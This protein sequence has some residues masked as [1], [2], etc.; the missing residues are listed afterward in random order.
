MKRIKINKHKIIF[1]LILFVVIMF[2]LIPKVNLIFERFNSPFKYDEALDKNIN[3]LKIISSDCIIALYDGELKEYF[4]HDKTFG[5]TLFSLKDYSINEDNIA[6]DCKGVLFK[7]QD[8][9]HNYLK[10]KNFNNGEITNIVSTDK[11]NSI[12]MYIEDDKVIYYLKDNNTMKINFFNVKTNKN[13]LILELE[14][15]MNEENY[16]YLSQPSIDDD[17]IV[18]SN[19]KKNEFD[20]K[21]SELY[22]FNIGNYEIKNLNTKKD[23][24]YKPIVYNNKLLGLKENIVSEIVPDELNNLNS[25]KY[26]ANCIAVFNENDNS[27]NNIFDNYNII[28]K[29]ENLF[30]ITQKDGYL[31]WMSSFTNKGYFYNLNNNQIETLFTEN[32][33]KLAPGDY[34]FSIVDIKNNIILYKVN[35]FGEENTSEQYIYKLK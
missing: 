8:D 18:F 2:I 10:Y 30:D 15:N 6:L 21:K 19:I 23:F 17:Y 24:I 4:L 9:N 31:Y 33:K 5:K 34:S 12:N 25:I 22:F 14:S 11:E 32:I 13:K 27:W 35:I 29:D 26:Y 16:N 3:A 20:E 7:F 28:K 1:S